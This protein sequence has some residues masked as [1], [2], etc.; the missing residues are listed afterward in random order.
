MNNNQ[1][2]AIYYG[3]TDASDVSNGESTFILFDDFNDGEFNTTK[4]TSVGTGTVSETNGYLLLD[5]TTSTRPY[6]RSVKKIGTEIVLFG[7][8]YFARV[9]NTV[10]QSTLGALICWDGVHGSTYDSPQNSYSLSS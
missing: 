7:D 5:S 6:V 4:W 8:V 2:I 1:T 3:N 10:Y 9:D